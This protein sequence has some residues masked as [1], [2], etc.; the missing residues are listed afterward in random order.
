MKTTMTIDTRDETKVI[1]TL[2]V[3]A[4]TIATATRNNNDNDHHIFYTNIDST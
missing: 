2:A 4:T 3:A 1:T